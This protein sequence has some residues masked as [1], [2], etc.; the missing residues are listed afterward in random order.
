MKLDTDKE[1]GNRHGNETDLYETNP[2]HD[3]APT[4]RDKLNTELHHLATV[5]TR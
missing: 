3:V 2:Y 5:W 1:A 4:A